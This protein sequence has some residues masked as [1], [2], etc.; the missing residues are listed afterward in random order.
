MITYL[1]DRDW[2]LREA[3]FTSIVNV[4]AHVGSRSLEEYILPLM[5]QA[6][7]GWSS[8]SWFSCAWMMLINF[9]TPDVEETVVAKVLSSLTSLAEL[10]LFHKLRIWELMSAATGFLYHPNV[11]IRQGESIVII[12]NPDVLLTQ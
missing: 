12:W 4:A 7:S 1:N 10:G 8:S 9:D 5:I 6:L 2:L 3:F 11:W